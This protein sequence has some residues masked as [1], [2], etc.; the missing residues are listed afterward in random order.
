MLEDLVLVKG[1]ARLPLDQEAWDAVKNSTDPNALQQF[2]QEYPQSGYVGVARVKIAALKVP[3]AVNTVAAP[4][5]VIIEPSVFFPAAN[6]P[7]MAL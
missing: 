6:R 3:V 7:P 1:N 4:P 2:I 5:A